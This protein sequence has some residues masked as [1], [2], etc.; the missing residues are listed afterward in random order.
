MS[1]IQRFSAVSTSWFLA[2]VVVE[3]V[4]RDK[5]IERERGTRRGRYES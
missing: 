5:S 4:S 1:G 2:E 3:E